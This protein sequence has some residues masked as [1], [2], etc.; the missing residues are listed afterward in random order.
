MENPSRV[1]LIRPSAL[2]DVCRT[3]PVLASLRVRFPDAKIDWLVQSDFAPA[4]AAHPALTRVV[5]FP[6]REVALA[7]LW[8]PSAAAALA[9]FLDSLGSGHY[10]LV[11]DC[12]GLG[13]SGFF[14]FL[15]RAPR[16][17]GY[18]NAGELGWMG[19]TERHFVPR[20]LHAVDRMLALIDAA[21]IPP[22][23]DLRLYTTHEDDDAALRLVGSGRHVV[24][25]PTSRWPGKRWPIERFAEVARA[26]LDRPGVDRVVVL[27]GPK[28][29]DQCGALL[30]LARETTSVVNLVGRTSI[31]V[32]MSIIKRAALVLA[33]DSAP[34][35]MAVGFD[36]PLVALLGPT[37][38]DLVGPY[39]RL[40]DVIQMIRNI[41]KNRHKDQAFGRAA[42]E[43]I[44]SRLVIDAAMH[45]L[46]P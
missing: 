13:R 25:A 29:E 37:R 22:V 15:T 44:P 10:G 1:L 14:T 28:E 31:G 43:A 40:Q 34:M 26:L 21:G 7:R 9:R 18:A 3:V 5:P 2:G 24:I 11:I 23:R 19:L 42:M 46:E 39:G 35:H 38:A 36:R 20:D 30:E 12:Q 17:V 6:R 41:P 4:V 32:S 45:R 16:R 27:G 8:R 33:N